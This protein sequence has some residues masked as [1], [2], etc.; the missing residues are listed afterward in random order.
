[1]INIINSTKKMVQHAKPAIGNSNKGV[2]DNLDYYRLES[3]E[4]IGTR[5]KELE[6]EWDVERT[7]ELKASLLAL[8]GII[9]GVSA[10]KKW[11][12]IPAA[13]CS[14]F[15]IHAIRGNRLPLTGNFRT[16]KQIAEEQFGLK[17]LLK[18]GSYK[19]LDS[20]KF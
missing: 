1:M 7:V 19:N 3:E 11:L 9:L 13:I 2:A 4:V 8:S 12:I 10:G 17:E 20:N 14:F 18:N 6:A 5:I 16:R 15:A